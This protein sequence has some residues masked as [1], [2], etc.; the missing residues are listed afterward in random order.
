[1]TIALTSP[2]V[3]PYLVAD[4]L[5]NFYG[6]AEINQLADRNNDGVPDV[7]A[8]GTVGNVVDYAIER[9]AAEVEGYLSSCY[10]LPLAPA[11]GFAAVHASVAM[12]I[13]EWVGVVARYKL[14]SDV[15]IQSDTEQKT[16]ARLRYED[17]LKLLAPKG[18]T[19]NCNVLGA[20][21]LKLIDA[22]IAEAN[23][24]LIASEGNNFSRASIR[25]Y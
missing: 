3:Y 20:S 23:M 13:A 24:P 25:G 5:R 21:V 22:N 15:R 6:A 19:C 14:W 7:G 9:A 1:M 2:L 17:L 12:R 4:E 11:A 16:E 10:V 18:A 8:V